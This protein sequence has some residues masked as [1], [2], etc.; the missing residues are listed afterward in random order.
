MTLF[1]IANEYDNCV[2]PGFRLD[3]NEHQ[4][5]VLIYFV[6]VLEKGGEARVESCYEQRFF[7]V[8][9]TTAC[10]LLPRLDPLEEEA[11]PVQVTVTI[12]PPSDGGTWKTDFYVS[13]TDAKTNQRVDCAVHDEQHLSNAQLLDEFI[14]GRYRLYLGNSPRNITSPRARKRL[15]TVR[16]FP[17]V[18]NASNRNATERLRHVLKQKLMN[19]SGP[20]LPKA[21]RIFGNSSFSLDFLGITFPPLTEDTPLAF[22]RSKFADFKTKYSDQI[23]DYMLALVQQKNKPPVVVQHSPSGNDS[24][25][26]SRATLF[27]GAGNATFDLFH[28]AIYRR[29]VSEDQVNAVS[30]QQL[31]PSRQFPSLHETVRIPED[32]VVLLNL[33]MLHGVFNDL[34]LELRDLPELGHLLLYPNKTRVTLLNKDA[35]RELPPKFQHHLYFQPEPDQNNENIPLPNPIAFSRR[36]KPYAT[37]QF[38]IANSLAGRIVNQ[39]TEAKIDL[40]VDAVNDAPRPLKPVLNIWVRIGVPVSFSL[41][42]DD[43]D[44][45]PFVTLPKTEAVGSTDLWSRFTFHNATTS[46]RNKQLLKIVQLPQFG[47][48]FECNFSCGAILFA[49]EE[50]LL[51]TSRIYSTDIVQATYS[52]SLVYIYHGRGQ[53][54]RKQDMT[55]SAVVDQ[56]WYKLSDGDPDVSSAMAAV[57]FILVNGMDNSVNRHVVATIQ[58]EE[59]SS[60]VLHLVTLDPL[61][62]FFNRETLLKV[63]VLPQNGALFQY[64]NHNNNCSGRSTTNVFMEVAGAHISTPDTIL[65][66]FCGRIIYV[67]ELDYFNLESEAL[68]RKGFTLDYLEYQVLNIPALINSSF[69]MNEKSPAES[70]A[71]GLETRRIELGVVNVPD[72]LLLLPPFVFTRNASSDKVVLT[73]VTF[74]D[75]DLSNPSGLYNI[76]LEAE[77]G[78]SELELGFAITDDDVMV[79]CPLERPCTLFLGTNKSLLNISSRKDHEL[80]FHITTQ[81]Y[82]PSHLHVIGTKTALSSALSELTFRDN[83]GLNRPHTS[84]FTV[85]IQR[86]QVVNGSEAESHQVKS[87]F[88][89]QYSVDDHHDLVSGKNRAL[90]FNSTLKRYCSTLLV[91]G[92]GWL[93]LSNNSFLLIGFCCCCCSK[94]RRKRRQ[95][96]MQKQQQFQAQVAQNDYEYTVLLMALADVLLEPKMLVSMCVLECCVTGTS[97]REHNEREM[98]TQAFILRN[99]IPL[100]ETER[101]GTRFVFRLVATEFT[102]RTDTRSERLLSQYH[103]FLQHSVAD[104]ALAVFC[105]LVG[106]KWF[107]MLLLPDGGASTLYLSDTGS[108]VKKLLDR[109]IVHVEA[110][111]VEIVVL[112]RACAKLFQRDEASTSHALDLYAV[113]LIF[114]NHFLG[115]A[116]WFSTSYVP[117]LALSLA[118]QKTLQVVAYK[119]IEFATEWIDSLYSRFPSAS[120]RNESNIYSS[121]SHYIDKYEAVLEI[122]CHSAVVASSYDPNTDRAEVDCELIGCCLMNLHSLLDSYFCAFRQRLLDPQ[123]STNLERTEDILSH[124][125]RLLKALSWPLAS[126]QESVAYARLELLSDPLWWNGFSCYEWQKRADQIVPSEVE[127]DQFKSIDTVYTILEQDGNSPHDVDWLS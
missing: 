23:V 122:I 14:T 57:N 108:E 55:T 30:R 59:D 37:V 125:N 53:D 15:G 66:D 102:K 79:G 35:F 105:R 94:V 78:V 19:I 110:L 121:G 39:S 41:E 127:S 3:L 58:L 80:Q 36:L 31:M 7:S 99:L 61:A 92:V 123:V 25:N 67:P 13:Y 76:F 85:W 115:P 17:L 111:P 106:A 64:N 84:E 29:A 68:V 100:L 91:L 96:L 38:G 4:V 1:S 21:M 113:H 43:I 18:R 62:A 40:F 9:K 93:V 89:I 124:V 72:A 87:K 74:E 54:E 119:I 70:F 75:P 81:L 109:L 44:G 51:A 28:F 52:T 33:T 22:L 27:Q 95:Q 10:Q 11:S 49:R 6:P 45:A 104:R 90:K 118:Q 12:N 24:T 103:S 82:D 5:L 126:I 48:L 56:L 50:E 47:K 77:D 60:Q 65:S 73:P 86:L 114:F 8:D 69:E 101:Q 71:S 97:N 42:G 34:R 120:A 26:F 32:S 88:T 98:L 116:L 46:P 112:C 2:D 83:S 63:T 20:R 107:S 16:E 117:G